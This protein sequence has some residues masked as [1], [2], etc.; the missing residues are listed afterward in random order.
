LYSAKAPAIRRAA[1]RATSGP[2][3][4]ACCASGSVKIGWQLRVKA[5]LVEA[6]DLRGEDPSGGEL[7]ERPHGEELHR[8]GLAAHGGRTAGALAQEEELVDVVN[9]GW[10]RMAEL[11]DQGGELHGS[12]AVAGFLE[13][14]A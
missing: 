1:S 11:V 9:A 2:K 3:G 8:V 7:R 10:M 12:G 6:L 5:V 14:L 13:D 4:G